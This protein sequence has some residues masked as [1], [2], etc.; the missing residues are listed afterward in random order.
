MLQKYFQLAFR[1]LWRNKFYTGINVTGLTIGLTAALLLFLWVNNEYSYDTFHPKKDQLYRILS[2]SSFGGEREY[3]SRTPLPL[4]D[5]IKEEVPEIQKVSSLMKGWKAELKVGNYI[6]ESDK[7]IYVEPD[8]L[9]MF[10]ISFAAGNR[11]TALDN[12]NSIVLS[13]AMATQLFGSQDVLGE[14]IRFKDQLDLIITGVVEDFPTN[15]HLKFEALVPFKNN[16]EKL[17]GSGAIHW[18]A[19]NYITYAL[20]RPN[21]TPSTINQKLTDL[22]PIRKDRTEIDRPFL[23]LQL[24]KDIHLGSDKLAYAPVPKGYSKMIQL[25]GLIGFL[26]LLI[27]CINYVNLTTARVAHR[28]KSIGVQK[29]VGASKTQLFSQHLIEVVLIVG[30]SSALALVLAH[31]CVPYFENLAGTTLLSADIFSVQS[32]PIILLTGLICVLLSGIQP[33]LVL[34]AFNPIHILKGSPFSNRSSKSKLRNILVV[35]QFVCSTILVIST[36][37]IMQQMDF[38]KQSKVGYDKE[39]VFSFWA[40]DKEKVNILKNELEKEISVEKV[41]ISNRDIVNVNS[42]IGGFSYE[43]M[44]EDMK[45]KTSICDISVDDNFK[46]FFGIQLKEGRW[47]LPEKEETESYIIN[48]A[49]VKYMQLEN[50]IGKWVE[51]WSMK[52]TIVGVVQDFHFQ[53]LH[54]AIEPLIFLHNPRDFRP[55]VKTTAANAAT[56]IT[57]TEKVFKKTYPNKVFNYKFLDES[58][59]ELYKKET[60]ISQV[61]Q[62]FALLTLF[63]SCLGIFGLATYTAER[64]GREIGIRK[65]LGASVLQI[66]QLLSTDFLKL[67]ILSLV[68]ALPIGGYFI[69]QWLNTFAYRMDIGWGLFGLTAVLTLLITLTTVSFQSIRAALINPAETLKN[70]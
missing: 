46:D 40:S 21:I 68:I 48:E 34:S 25:I 47:F 60:R 59:D 16:V 43:G 28:T 5:A 41:T 23:E 13:K 49:A 52:G 63:L 26:I 61:F 4:S 6:I 58:F 10:N 70:E 12:P 7:V 39:H 20:L 9:E 27:A 55:Y 22:L 37:S 64:K 66:V 44:P 15:S 1:K 17:Q 65:I 53:S 30:I 11:K 56:A 31:Q 29:I 42:R 14:T 8:F 67:I 57:A 32:L 2:N 18:G 38:I 69:Q 36:L 35:I 50:P 54:H 62:I 19:Y 33:A 45:D 3:S 51:F 24:V